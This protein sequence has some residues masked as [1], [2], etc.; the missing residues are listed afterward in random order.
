M[1]RYYIE[2]D[3]EKTL[4]SLYEEWFHCE[5]LGSQLGPIIKRW[6]LCNI[7]WIFTS[8]QLFIFIKF[9]AF[10]DYLQYPLCVFL[11]RRLAIE[12][13]PIHLQVFCIGTT[14][15]WKANSR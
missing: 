11:F 2:K 8:W 1:S 3:G 10:V 5:D 14:Q 9:A 12:V 15:N 13:F 7:I 4:E 6:F